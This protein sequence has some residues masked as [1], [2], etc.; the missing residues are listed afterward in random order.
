MT[1]GELR[2]ETDL[3]T[4]F[5]WVNFQCLFTGKDD[6]L[7]ALERLCVGAATSLST[8]ERA[9]RDRFSISPKRYVVVQRLNHV[10]AALLH[11]R[12][13]RSIS[14]VAGEW[15]F[16]HMGQFAADYKLLFGY[17]PSET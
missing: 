5:G 2:T 14:D 12:D 10:H 1:A 17:L 13:G 8:L 11:D 7:D 16:W 3:F 15:S 9:F 4:L 6:E